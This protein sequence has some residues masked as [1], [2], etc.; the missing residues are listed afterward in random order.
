MLNNTTVT[1][2]GNLAGDPDLSFTPVLLK[3]RRGPEG[4]VGWGRHRRG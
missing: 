3:P 2:V 1:F 4:E